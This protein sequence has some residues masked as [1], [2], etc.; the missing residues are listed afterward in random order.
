MA[1]N[2]K[3]WPQ[4]KFYFVTRNPEIDVFQNLWAK[5]KIKET[6][7]AVLAGVADATVKRMFGGQT[8]DPRHSTFVKLAVAMGHSYGLHRNVEP[9]YE[10]EVPKAREER[11]EYR[12]FLR[13]KRAKALKRAKPT[14]TRLRVV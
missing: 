14:R 10:K 6:D 8:R 12:A 9:D 7:L 4:R 11:K 2:G 5:E 3:L 13:A 1:K